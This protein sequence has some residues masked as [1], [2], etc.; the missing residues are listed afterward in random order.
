MALPRI[1]Q[2]V[3]AAADL[4]VVTGDIERELGL[5]TPFHDEGV[6]HFGLHNA[7]YSLGDSFLEV[8]SPVRSDT[9][10]GRHLDRCGGDAGY[11]VMFEVSDVAA[12]RQRLETL[13]VRLV[14]DTTHPDIVDLHLHPKDVGGALV[15]LDVT[16]PVGSWRWGGPEW[17]A[18]APTPPPG[19]VRALTVAVAEPD[20]VARRWA[21]VV[22][23]DTPQDN[24]LLLAGGEQ[25]I[26]FIGIG[27]NGDRFVA[28]EVDVPGRTGPVDIAGVT[29]DRVPAETSRTAS[30]IGG[31]QA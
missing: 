8:V 15:A 10:V 17:T 28:V 27:G 7:V 23:L 21:E 6:G 4:A 12:T 16:D 5:D 11:M 18:V 26:R 24:V 14:W 3:L 1:R 29:F 13:G 2:V 9:A 20:K 31:S 30:D 22:G 25:H 19:G